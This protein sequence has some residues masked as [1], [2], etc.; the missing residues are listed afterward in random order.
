MRSNDGLLCASHRP[1][2]KK[3]NSRSIF[4]R[5][6]ICSA[7]H[8]YSTQETA[9]S[10]PVIR[11]YPPLGVAMHFVCSAP[12]KVAK[13]VHCGEPRLDEGRRKFFQRPFCFCHTIFATAMESNGSDSGRSCAMKICGIRLADSITTRRHAQVTYLCQASGVG[14]EY[15]LTYPGRKVEQSRIVYEFEFLLSSEQRITR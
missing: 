14:K 11:L 3:L 10:Q 13:S 2:H 7:H 1:V 9:H 5:R 12:K 15:G 4:D 8:A 6:Q